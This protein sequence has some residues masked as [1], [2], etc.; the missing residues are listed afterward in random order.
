MSERN[1]AQIQNL[2]HDFEDAC[3]SNGKEPE[4]ENSTDSHS[5]ENLSPQRARQS[6]K[7]EALVPSNGS[8]GAS[9]LQQKNLSKYTVEDL[10]QISKRDISFGVRMPGQIVEESLDI[11]NKSGHDFVVQI[12]VTCLND[13]LQNTEEYVYSVRRSHLYEYN[14]KHF[15]IMAPYSCAGFKFALKIPNLRLGGNVIGQAEVS[16]QG[17]SGSYVL[18]FT[19]RVSIP[20]VFCPKELHFAGLNYNIIK[21]A[22]KE[23]KKQD[24]KIPLRNNGEVPVSM[25][26]EFYEPKDA[27][28]KTERA[29]FDCLVHPNTITINP[30]STALVTVMVKPWKMLMPLKGGLEKSKGSRKILIGRVRDS[31]V[32]YSFVF[33][34]EIY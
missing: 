25:E 26:L 34:I 28:G 12:I 3:E 29:Y 6:A 17:V 10:L 30:N 21:L 2:V 24:H 16:I 33:W 8:R 27:Q 14:D 15:L 20:K 1:V 11:V 5:K 13:D 22:V 7:I 19:S 31:A 9:P 18:D 4:N 23:G 32:V